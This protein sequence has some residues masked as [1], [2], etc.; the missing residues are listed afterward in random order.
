MLQNMVSMPRAW[1]RVMLFAFDLALIPV[2]FFFAL[3]LR[4]GEIW[5][6]P[7]DLAGALDADRLK[8]RGAIL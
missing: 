6:D 7:A 2:A 3:A 5:P 8:E 4:L 1:K